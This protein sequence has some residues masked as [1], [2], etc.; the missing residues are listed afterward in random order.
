M[1][2][3]NLLCLVDQNV[4]DYVGLSRYGSVIA[5]DGPSDTNFAIYLTRQAISLHRHVSDGAG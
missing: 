5:V 4:G 2:V 1:Q 3:Q